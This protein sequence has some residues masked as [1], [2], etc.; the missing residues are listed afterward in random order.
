MI[1]YGGA[2]VTYNNGKDVNISFYPVG[3][4]HLFTYYCRNP[5]YLRLSLEAVYYFKLEFVGRGDWYYHRESDSWKK[6]SSN[7]IYILEAIL[8]ENAVIN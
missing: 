2:K 8:E 7:A 1:W 3:S 5:F 6:Y 4:N